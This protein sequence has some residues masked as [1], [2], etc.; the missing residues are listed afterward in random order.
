MPKRAATRGSKRS[1][2]SQKKSADDSPAEEEYEVEQI[3]GRRDN[4]GTGMDV[5]VTFFE[6][7]YVTQYISK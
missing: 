4:N 5:T 6:K 3:L 7:Y 2:K 1:R